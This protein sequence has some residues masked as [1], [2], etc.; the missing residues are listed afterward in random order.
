MLHS[1]ACNVHEEIRQHRVRKVSFSDLNPH[2][3][4]QRCTYDEYFKDDTKQGLQVAGK[5]I[6]AKLL[7]DALHK[8]HFYP[9]YK[10]SNL[11]Q[12]HQFWKS[13]IYT[14]EASK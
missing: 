6:T 10:A 9:I 4:R 12:T 8:I 1:E 11:K 5:R 7:A 2:E 13:G 14:F 3:E